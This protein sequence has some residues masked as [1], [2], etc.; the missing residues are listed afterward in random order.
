MTTLSYGDKL[1]NPLWQKKRLEILN[2]DEFTCQLCS[3]TTT[4]LHIH[5]KEYLPGRDPWEYEDENFQTLC[6]HCH[7]VV[8]FYKCSFRVLAS[9]KERFPGSNQIYISSVLKANRV[10]HEL[11]IAVDII[12]DDGRFEECFS[13]R[14]ATVVLYEKLFQYSEKLLINGEKNV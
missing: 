7:V 2:R 9:G 14:R 5:H 1:K 4:E 6:K 11:L 10:E 13:L 8:E 3:D 12:F